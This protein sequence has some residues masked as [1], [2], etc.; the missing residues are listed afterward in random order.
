MGHP[1]RACL[2]LVLIAS[3]PAGRAEGRRELTVFAAASL[4]E[5]FAELGKTFERE[6]PQTKVTFSFAGSRELR[7]QIEHGAPADVFASADWND[8]QALVAAKL[9]SA[10]R[11]VT[12]SESVVA[13]PR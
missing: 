2:A 3:A 7:T 4:R 5:A 11:G 13:G 10:A 1:F 8:M 12:R 6:H 9:A